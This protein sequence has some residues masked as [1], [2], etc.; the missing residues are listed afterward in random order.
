MEAPPPTPVIRDLP[1]GPWIAGLFVGSFGALMV[2][3]ALGTDAIMGLFIGATLCGAGLLMV[4]LFPVLTVRVDRES[5]L[6][7][8]TYRSL[9]TKRVKE[10]PLQR[11]DSIDVERYGV[12]I[13]ESDGHVTPLRFLKKAPV[14]TRRVANRL[15]E[16]AG[17]G[18]S[19]GETLRMLTGQDES[20]NRQ[21][22]RRQENLTGLNDPMSETAGVR[23][24]VQS[25][26]MGRQPVTRWFSPDYK[27][28]G[29]FVYIAQVPARMPTVGGMVGK[30][31]TRGVIGKLA[32]RASMARY[33]FAGEDLPDS[34]LARVLPLDPPLDSHFMA[35]SPDASA[36][37]RILNPSVAEALDEWASRHPLRAVQV[38]SAAEQLVV[39]FSPSGV[40]AATPRLL[41]PSHLAELAAT[42]AEL[43][44]A[45]R[46]EGP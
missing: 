44:K 45:Q 31:F 19:D 14:W 37:R 11:I 27:T 7:T 29:T 6:L 42:G 3:S 38:G 20:V 34:N 9:L 33:G 1:W 18:G 43:V 8:L 36:A 35:L 28:N 4:A 21:I 24:N 17:V 40:Y 12:V 25:T 5:G 39:L 10:I 26:G 15:R 23:W 46:R 22:R 2:Q 30:L 13:T 41:D 16:L 32:A